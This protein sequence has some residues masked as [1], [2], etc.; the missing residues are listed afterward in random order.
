ML[1][2]C[3]E[4]Q[5]KILVAEVNGEVAGYA[6]NLM[7]VRNEA[8]EDGDLEY[9]LV[10]DVVVLEKY[11]KSGIDRKLPLESEAYA[12]ACDVKWLRIAVLA[13]N[14]AAESL[15]QSLGLSGCMSKW[16]RT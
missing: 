15:Y 6:T 10:S 12:R 8:L 9:G 4:C 16:K 13:S 11:R 14:Q 7:R 5:G 3:R 1:K 2:Q